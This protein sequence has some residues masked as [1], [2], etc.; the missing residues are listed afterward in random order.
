[1]EARIQEKASAAPKSNRELMLETIVRRT[2]VCDIAVDLRDGT[3][4]TLKGEGS[5]RLMQLIGMSGDYE[6]LVRRMLPRL[7]PAYR[8]IC[9]ETFGLARLRQLTDDRDSRPCKALP[10]EI[11][12]AWY[13]FEIHA[14]GPEADSDLPYA[15]VLIRNVTAEAEERN[16]RIQERAAAETSEAILRKLVDSLFG[17]ILTIDL[18]TLKYR[19]VAGTGMEP[20][21]RF[22]SQHDDYRVAYTAKLSHLTA[23]HARQMEEC[24][25]PEKLQA[26]AAGGRR[27]FYRIVEHEAV[28]MG[29]HCWEEMSVYF[30]NDD[31]G[32]RVAI[33]LVRDVTEAHNRIDAEREADRRANEAKSYFF[34]SVSHDIRTPLNAI[35]GYA[36][37]L[38]AGLPGKAEREQ[39]LDSIVSSGQMLRDL[40]NDVLDLAK[41]ESGKMEV[42]PES[43]DVAQLVREVLGSFAL[44]SGRS[45][46][47]L[48]G[49]T[50]G[51]PRLMVD[52]QRLR[53]ILFNLVGNAVKF[54]AKGSITVTTA[55]ANGRLTLSV[56]DTGCGIDPQYQ[57]RLMQP[58]VQAPG[59]GRHGGTGLGL[60]IC[61]QLARRMNGTLSLKSTLGE[62]SVFTLEI[63]ADEASEAD[64][65]ES[66]ADAASAFVPRL[67]LKSHEARVLIVD[68]STVNLKV[69]TALLRQLGCQNVRQAE[70]GRLALEALNYH[71]VDVVLTDMWMPEMDGTELTRQIRR[72]ADLKGLPVYAVTADVE[73]VK[74]SA[75]KGFT[76]VLLKP[77]TIKALSALFAS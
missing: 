5:D 4:A 60:A 57:D 76:G 26:E 6:D 14:L 65:H 62:G 32:R 40:V 77:L 30:G 27:G 54:T 2:C 36:E 19:I 3:Y 42:H 43:C 21:V 64:A 72:R 41:L 52:S 17:Y 56:Q 58:F 11:N 34:S 75:E 1:M 44:D 61:N 45:G 46:V 55:Y 9:E 25:A 63:P 12:G 69:L 66:R 24:F 8:S 15:N 67:S 29:V 51:L 22:L 50:S 37:L 59:G 68:D 28:V 13:W 47:K 39:A 73:A 33:A 53:Q 10:V 16:R 18:E 31:A 71:D 38:R 20:S 48:V 74:T 70:N 35:L 7:S 23:E 49:K